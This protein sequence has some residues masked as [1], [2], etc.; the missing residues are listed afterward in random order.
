MVVGGLVPPLELG[1]FTKNAALVHMYWL[2]MNHD[3]LLGSI[4]YSFF[5]SL[6]P[7]PFYYYYFNKI[8]LKKSSLHIYHLLW[9]F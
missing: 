2:L 8:A 9:N 4:L 3:L 5:Y 6:P 1:S 7:P